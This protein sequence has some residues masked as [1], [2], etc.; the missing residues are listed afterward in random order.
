M[1]HQLLTVYSE[2][3]SLDKEYYLRNLDLSSIKGYKKINQ[4]HQALLFLLA[5]P[6]NKE[7]ELL[8]K[9]KLNKL[10]D[11]VKHTSL[12]GRETFFGSG[13]AYSSFAGSYSY[14]LCKWLLNNYA[15][16]ISIHSFSEDAT[17]PREVL[18]ALLNEMEYEL[19]ANEELKPKNW[20]R[21]AFGVNDNK[22]LLPKII[23]ILGSSKN[24]E[25]QK[26][27]LFE[28]LGIFIEVKDSSGKLSK[29]FNKLSF[30]P[31][32]YHTGPLFKKI[33]H[34]DILK[35]KLF[36]AV[37]LS[38]QE[39]KEIISVSR[40]ALAIL[41]RETDPITYCTEDSIQYYELGRG[42]SIALFSMRPTYRMPLESYIGFMMFKNGYPFSYGGAWLCG[43]RALIGINIFETYRGGESAFVFAQLLRVYHQVFGATEFEVE[44]YQFGKNNPEGIKSGAFW[45]YYRFG[46]RP[47]DKELAHLAQKEHEKILSNSSY[48][49][50]YE[51]LKKFTKG[52]LYVNYGKHTQLYSPS[53]IS[54]HITYLIVSKYQ[55]SRNKALLEANKILKH[56]LNLKTLQKSIMQKS[57]W[58]KLALFLAFCIDWKKQ[59]PNSKLKL[60]ELIEW[61][62]K[63]EFVYA[64]KLSKW[65]VLRWVDLS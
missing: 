14:T 25:E 18:G 33:N 45:F 51:I 28:Q 46:F 53:Q 6:D 21:Q 26:E 36:G 29:T 61:K 12:R 60:I 8:A 16:E 19:Q 63:S 56:N 35:K 58:S 17:H 54:N 4:F 39:Y 31:S 3:S 10:L 11:K 38:K 52:N 41:N 1:N 7:T 34:T 15:N 13:I 44:P 20:L 32:F 59:D 30:A 23:E 22:T 50:S 43:K 9:E 42:Y 62:E 47:V 40:F 24:T 49:S 48:R 65:N 5:Y 2:R 55:G 57:S 64:K 37:R 27:K